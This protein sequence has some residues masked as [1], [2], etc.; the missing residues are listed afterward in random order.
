M[1][2][3]TICNH[4]EKEKINIELINETPMRDIERL[5]KVSKSSLSRHKQWCLS[6]IVTAALQSAPKNSEE[7]E[8]PEPETVRG[9]AE[10]MCG[11]G[12][13]AILQALRRKDYK[14]AF[15]G[16]REHRGYMEVIGKVTGELNPAADPTGRQPMFMLPAG[17]TVSVTVSAPPAPAELR[18]VTPLEL[19]EN[20]EN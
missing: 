19:P 1:M 3:C 10:E 9:K 20:T 11:K 2:K 6:A 18:N 5:F 16:M 14:T 13:L 4:Q 17:T 8:G 15:A 7:E 12:R